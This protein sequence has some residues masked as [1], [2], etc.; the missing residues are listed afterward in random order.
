MQRNTNHCLS[1][2]F[3][4]QLVA[5]DFLH[6]RPW[7]LVS[8]PHSRLPWAYYRHYPECI[9]NQN[10]HMQVLIFNI[11]YLN[12]LAYNMTQVYGFE[13]WTI[14]NIA[15]SRA[16][17]N[18]RDKRDRKPNWFCFSGSTPVFIISLP[19]IFTEGNTNRGRNNI[20]NLLCIHVQYKNK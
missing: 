12:V 1:D 9:W 17:P 20:V 14:T 3:P 7:I 6:H 19:Q 2:D 18:K 8:T 15:G 13:M 16:R 11:F 10:T 4:L 5:L